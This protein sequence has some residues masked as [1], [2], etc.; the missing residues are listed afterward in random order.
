KQVTDEFEI[1]IT[2]SKPHPQ[3]G[4]KSLAEIAAE[5]GLS[6]MDAAKRLQPG[7]AVYHNM[8]EADMRRILAD[9]GSMIGSDG[10]PEDP[11]PHPRLWG[12]FPR[13]LGHYSRDLGF[14][15]LAEAVRKMTGLSAA[16]FGLADRGL[17]REGYVA[18][19]VLFDPARIIDTVDYGD[20]PRRAAG[21][22][23]VWVNGVRSYA[24]GELTGPRAGRFVPRAGTTV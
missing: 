16:R 1:T 21:V 3:M 14:F 10:L 4:G 12:T 7:G 19:L 8:S 20:S 22:L 9:P 15:P 5:W 13:V 11:R 24:E 2:W 6:L 17:V 23:G 18:D